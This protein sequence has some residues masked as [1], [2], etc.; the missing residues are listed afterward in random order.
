MHKSSEKFAVVQQSLAPID[1]K[2]LVKAFGEWPKLTTFD[3]KR[4][5]REAYGIICQAMEE[6]EAVELAEILNRHSI[7]ATAT[8]ERLLALAPITTVRKA[9]FSSDKIS[10]FVYPDTPQYFPWQAISVISLAAYEQTDTKLAEQGGWTPI[11]GG[12]P[13]RSWWGGGR[14]MPLVWKE[15]KFKEIKTDH[16]F[17]DVLCER[18]FRRFQIMPN[19]FDYEY[20]GGRL[21]RDYVLN[22]I[23]LVNDLKHFA[24]STA[25][26]S[27]FLTFQKDQQT[28]KN[29]DLK[30]HYE[31]E[32]RW[33]RWYHLT[34]P[35][36]HRGSVSM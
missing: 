33:H 8:S 18:P 5:S 32:L 11:W 12:A 16:I 28:I 1:Q 22:F 21:T 31:R 25:F 9:T 29:F 30:V 15:A 35:Y 6:H 4:L 2:K 19:T 7:G 17:L 20:L 34:A 36:F 24:Q 14:V 27:S 10:L 3:A 26:N 13:R 23:E